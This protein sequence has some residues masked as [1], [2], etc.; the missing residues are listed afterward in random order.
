MVQVGERR[1]E[2]TDSQDGLQLG[3]LHGERGSAVVRRCAAKQYLLRMDQPTDQPRAH[4][5]LPLRPDARGTMHRA[6]E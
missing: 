2:R 5:G 3:G 1:D 4:G 6:G